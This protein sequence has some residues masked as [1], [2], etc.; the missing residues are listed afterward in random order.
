MGVLGYRTTNSR[1]RCWL[2]SDSLSS[3]WEYRRGQ[4][5]SRCVLAAEAQNAASPCNL[6]KP[7]T[8]RVCVALRL[9]AFVSSRGIILSV[10]TPTRPHTTNV[11]AR[12]RSAVYKVLA[13][14]VSLLHDYPDGSM[15]AMH[16]PENCS[17][18]HPHTSGHE[19]MISAAFLAATLR[20]ALAYCFSQPFPSP[21]VMQCNVGTGEMTG[22]LVQVMKRCACFPSAGM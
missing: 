9:C 6:T 13:S 19:R 5:R 2:P 10:T 15:Q 21:Y 20:G 18:F 11:A 14:M 8:W 1:S 4:P 16:T 22:E 12:T 17:N 3:P 7:G